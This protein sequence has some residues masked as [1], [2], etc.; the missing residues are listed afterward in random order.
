MRYINRLFTYLL[1]LRP[2]CQRLSVR[3]FVICSSAVS[4]SHIS[5]TEQ[6]RPIV[7]IERYWWVLGTVV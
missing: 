2:A 7:T 3:P 6:D 1:T 4:P 5:I